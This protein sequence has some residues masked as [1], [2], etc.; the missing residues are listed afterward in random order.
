MPVTRCHAQAAPRMGRSYGQ[1]GLCAI[2]RT[3]DGASRR[4]ASTGDT[5]PAW[6][7]LA[8]G[9]PNLG[10][11]MDIPVIVVAVIAGPPA[12]RERALG[13]AA[14]AWLIGVAAVAWGPAH[15]D[16]V[17]AGSFSEFWLPWVVVLVICAILVLGITAVR[18][19]RAAR[20]PAGVR[21]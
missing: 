1:S 17:H 3:G 20:G 7:A 5:A 21:A 10:G 19:R 4:F 18:R 11:S 16:D 14:V 13:I 8:C 9:Q 6:S 2:G 15:N 12:S